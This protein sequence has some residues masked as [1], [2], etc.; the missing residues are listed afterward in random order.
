MI[1]KVTPKKMSKQ[2]RGEL[3]GLKYYDIV[4]S[5]KATKKSPEE[6]YYHKYTLGQVLQ[7]T[8]TQVNENGYFVALN[9]DYNIFCAAPQN[10]KTAIVDQK[11]IIKITKK[12]DDT[13]KYKPGEIRGR[14]RGSDEYRKR[15]YGA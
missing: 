2:S 1:K 15:C 13:K 14:A 3:I 5:V 9:P 11:V 7:G 10:G 4:A 12:Y 6:I 8:V